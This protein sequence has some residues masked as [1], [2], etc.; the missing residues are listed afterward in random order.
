MTLD[1]SYVVIDTPLISLETAKTHLH[2][3]G[4]DADEDIAAKLEVAQAQVLAKLGLAGDVSW[5]EATVPKPVRHAML[6]LLDAFYENRGGD[7][8]ADRLR[9]G[10]EA[11]DLLLALYRD[12]SLA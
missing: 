6:L 10:L 7:E 9:K 5:T 8:G 2:I 11:V 1:F 12:P 4:T 3:T